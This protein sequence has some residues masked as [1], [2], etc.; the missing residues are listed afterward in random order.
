MENAVPPSPFPRVVEYVIDAD[1]LVLQT[2][3]DWAEVAVDNDAPELREIRG[4]DLFSAIS[5]ANLGELWRMILASVRRTQEGQTFDL[6]CDAPSL[7]RFI[8]LDVR[9]DENGGVRFS[10]RETRV[11][12]RE[13]IP[14]LDRRA[15]RND[16]LLLVCAW[17]ARV[18]ATTWVPIE[19]AVARLM[20]FEQQLLPRIS[21]G[22]CPDCFAKTM[23]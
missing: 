5:D 20:L 7:R 23:P 2:G 14:L 22:I 21:H 11:E 6:R 18:Q 1:D 8:E 13:P 17:C 15:E 4:I 16:S 10:S 9:P 12:V 3:A 19:D